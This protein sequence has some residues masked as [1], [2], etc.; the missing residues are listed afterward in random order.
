MP[1]N[2]LL[3][4]SPSEDGG[5]DKY[6]EAFRARGFRPVSVP[7]LET[8]HRNL[9]KLAEVVRRR[10]R[11]PGDD[12]DARYA[13]VIVTSGRACEAWQTVVHD[14]SKESSSSGDAEDGQT[15][16]AVP[17]YAVGAA[18]ATALSSIG[19]AYPSSP[20]AP[21]DIRGGAESG[22][23][24]KLAHFIL[25][26]LARSPTRHGKTLLYLTGDKNRDTLPRILSE[27]GLELES[28]QVYATQGSSTFDADLQDRLR[29][30]APD[31][32][33]QW[34]IVYF[35]P[36]AAKSVSPTIDKYF[37]SPRTDGP[38]PSA[39]RRARIAAI[40]PTTS[41]FLREE[42]DMEVAVVAEKPTPESLSEGIADW[43]RN[44][45]Q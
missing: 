26:D 38:S 17:F 23:A 31:P 7:V 45:G 39:K 3:L 20:H 21:H 12:A 10:G 18:T 9:D 24:E 2:V 6:E 33:E 16:A 41:T 36:S 22:T 13:G 42:L 19:S 27:G 29:E 32:A 14:L 25:A 34:W 11:L 5:P 28:L 4:R 1:T 30:T 8:V 15:W 43:E 35:A 37:D 40:G 44:H